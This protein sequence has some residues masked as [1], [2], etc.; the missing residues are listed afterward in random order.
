[1]KK[2]TTLIATLAFF[3]L[4][5]SNARA[6]EEG[7]YSLFSVGVTPLKGSANTT[8]SLGLSLGGGY[9]FNKYVGIEGQLALLGMATTNSLSAHALAMTLNGY[10]PVQEHLNL[11]G[12]VGKSYTTVSD[13]TSTTSVSQSGMTTVYG[14][15]LEYSSNDKRKYRFGVDHYDLS[16]APGMTL[17]TNY[18]YI[19]TT[20][21][22]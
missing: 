9:N 21:N 4:N 12:K 14:Y 16:V 17:S 10:L 19:A 20:L 5:L 11:F 1:M 8:I 7:I 6:A 18:I 3:T 15:G 13:N 22:Y 2:I